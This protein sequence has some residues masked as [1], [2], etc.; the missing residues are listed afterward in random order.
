MVVVA[1]PSGDGPHNFGHAVAQA[2]F[3]R[4]LAAIPSTQTIDHETWAVAV[5]G[6]ADSMAL[7]R[8]LAENL[9]PNRQKLTALTVDHGLRPAAADEA[10]QVAIWCQ[11]MN[12]QHRTLTVENKAPATGL[13]A[14]A[15][16]QR[17]RV[18]LQFC[19]NRGIRRLFL[20]H[21]SD[22]QVETVMQRIRR[23]SGPDGLAGMGR[24]QLRRGVLLLRPLLGNRHGDL[25]ATCQRFDQAWFED[26][27]NKDHRYQRVRDR[28]LLSMLPAGGCDREGLRRFAAVMG[29]LRRVMDD[30]LAAFLIANA[31]YHSGAWVSLDMVAMRQLPRL[32]TVL[33]LSRLLP[34]IGGADYPPRSARLARLIDQIH[35]QNPPRFKATLSGCVLEAKN[36]SLILCREWQR[37][38]PLTCPDDGQWHRWDNRYEIRIAEGF[39]AVICSSL[40][41]VAWGELRRDQRLGQLTDSLASLPLQARS[42]FPIMRKLDDDSV[43]H[44]VKG[45]LSSQLKGARRPVELR[46][47]PNSA[48]LS[49]IVYRDF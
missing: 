22:D 46:F 27:S 10:R 25:V 30:H 42:A 40:G 39:G 21:H 1:D 5:S 31:R 18:M 7:L 9:G 11:N 34:A 14:W 35:T 12:I 26:P 48:F 29:R 28:C 33:L 45:D 43:V 47:Q 6:G 20:G 19:R 17:Y 41:E 4:F 16:D 49:A 13:Q 2:D 36:D 32:P 3:A 15:R 24:T 8:L 38:A 23:D 44:Q 37:V